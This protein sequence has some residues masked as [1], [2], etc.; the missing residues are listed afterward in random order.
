MGKWDCEDNACPALCTVH[1]SMHVHT[2]DFYEYSFN[3]TVPCGYTLV[4]VS[5]IVFINCVVLTEILNT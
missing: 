5:K 4:R 2:F 3:P 1:G